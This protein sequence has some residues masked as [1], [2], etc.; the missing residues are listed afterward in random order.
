MGEKETRK[1]KIGY[2]FQNVYHNN[3]T[4]IGSVMIYLAGDTKRFD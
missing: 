2:I 3:V 4:N 1:R